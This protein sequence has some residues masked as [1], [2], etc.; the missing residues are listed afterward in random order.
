MAWMIYDFLIGFFKFLGVIGWQKNSCTL[1]LGE[2]FYNFPVNLGRTV[3][4]FFG[5]S[6]FSWSCVFA[7]SNFLL[8]RQH[9]MMLITDRRNVGRC[10]F[11]RNM[12]I[13]RAIRCF[14]RQ[15]FVAFLSVVLM[16][17]LQ[18]RANFLNIF[19]RL[20]ML[21][22]GAFLLISALFSLIFG[23]HFSHNIIDCL[24]ICFLRKSLYT[25]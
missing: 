11:C 16:V 23:T 1:W 20:I 5:Q 22:S 7:I 6:T 13:L 10:I 8:L 24:R 25:R 2:A 15:W 19:R 9:L 21:R 14:W 4:R 18:K 3:C 12:V 17:A